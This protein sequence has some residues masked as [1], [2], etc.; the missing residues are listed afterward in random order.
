ML[1]TDRTPGASASAAVGTISVPFPRV[2]VRPVVPVR[3]VSL[4]VQ[5]DKP[6][7]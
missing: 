1:Q 3:L 7:G 5:E 6:T 2:V 4:V